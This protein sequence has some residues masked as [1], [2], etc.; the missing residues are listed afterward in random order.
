MPNLERYTQ[1]LVNGNFK[2]VGDGH[3]LTV[4]L[5]VFILFM[6]GFLLLFLV[7][8]ITR[9]HCY[10]P[11]DEDDVFEEVEFRLTQLEEIEFQLSQLL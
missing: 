6:C 10:D 9:N 4:F 3:D 7:R 11:E 8:C 2:S 1:S 5:T